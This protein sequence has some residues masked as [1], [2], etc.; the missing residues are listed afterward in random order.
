[1]KRDQ[2]SIENLVVVDRYPSREDLYAY[3]FVHARVKS[4]IRE[5]L[6]TAVFVLN[7]RVPKEYTFEGVKVKQGNS[8]ALKD[9]IEIC[10]T[11]AIST[12]FL[13]KEIW[14]VIEP[15]SKN[16]STYIWLHGSEIQ[17]WSRRYFAFETKRQKLH[18]IRK[19][20]EYYDFWRELFYDDAHVLH[21]IFVSQYFANEVMDD[22]ELKL[23]S[24]K[25][26]VIH[27]FIDTNLFKYVKK[28]PE[29]R[30]RIL[31]IRPFASKKYANDLTVSAILDL[32]DEPFFKELSFTIVGDGDLF[33]ATVAPLREF[34]NVSL[35]KIFLTQSDIANMYKN[36]GVFINPTRWDSHGVSRDEAMSSGLVPITSDNSAIPEFVSN[37][38]GFLVETEDHQALARAIKTLYR[39]PELF[40]SKS[41]ASADRVRSQSD[42]T[43]TI[44]A[45]ISLIKGSIKRYGI[46]GQGVFKDQTTLR[47]KI[48]RDALFDLVD[49]QRG[50]SKWHWQHHAILEKELAKLKSSES[51]RL[52]LMITFPLRKLYHNRILGLPL[53]AIMRMKTANA[54]PIVASTDVVFGSMF[55][56]PKNR[57]FD[58]KEIKSVR[59]ITIAAI[60]DEFTHNSFHYECNLVQ[61]TPDGWFEEIEQAQPDLLFIESAWRGKD[62][63]WKDKINRTPKELQ[64]IIDYCKSRDIPTVFWNKEDPAHTITFMRTAS[65]FDYVFTTDASC[66]P[67]YREVLGHNRIY[68]LPF[69]AQP[70]IHNPIEEY[71]RKDKFNFAGSYYARFK[72]RCRDFDTVM[73]AVLSL[74]EVD[75][76][77]RYYN[78]VRTHAWYQFPDRYKE[79]IVG[80]LP[81][82]DINKAYKGYR[83]AITMNTVKYS[84]TMF[85]RRAFELL[86]SNTIT[87]GN[88]SEGVEAALGDMVISGK[89]SAEIKEQFNKLI[90]SNESEHR[91]RLLGL[92]SI[93]S[94]HTYEQ[95]LHRVLGKVF[96]NFELQQNEPFAVIIS[97]VK[98][99][100]EAKR[101]TNFFKQ[102]THN[103]RKLYLLPEGNVSLRELGDDEVKIL[104]NK[105]PSQ[106]AKELNNSFFGIFD[107]TAYYGPH[108][109]SD[110]LLSIQYIDADV[111]GKAAY[112]EVSAPDLFVRNEGQQYKKDVNIS[113]DRGLIKG[114]KLKINSLSDIKK[115]IKSN[116]V[117]KKNTFGID[118]FSYVSVSE[119]TSQQK[120]VVDGVMN[121]DTGKSIDDIYKDA[122][123][124][125]EDRRGLMKVRIQKTLRLRRTWPAQ[126]EL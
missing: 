72:D 25:Y 126:R 124:I 94:Q 8:E 107:P 96:S 2:S 52:G 88:Y 106:F 116:R 27:N 120:E 114:Q 62:E 19:Y 82:K 30:K 71:D 6:K 41:Q 43:R 70:R 110:I 75:I 74:K 55:K 81:Y 101:V 38:E 11:K 115:L 45:E 108:Y 5:G 15:F 90:T 63:L 76:Y 49:D 1:M 93:L 77:D 84:P 51:Y 79:Y 122:D 121:I 118:E 14:A 4:Y 86:A 117:Y 7:D 85:A 83:Y 35:K 26:S 80:N 40:L 44:Q 66:I 61:L 39:D 97:Q 125:S 37:K 18:N 95:R 21:F 69:A 109:V 17:D 46:K 53:R 22:L 67:F 59:E 28:T 24:K 33:D 13:T 10:G 105:L 98:S 12:H 64:D 111:I 58:L 103:N 112:Y 3:A 123:A 42:F 104:D 99:I 68:L 47:E 56:P 54:R 34:S 87:V 20:R 119:L 23:D 73:N 92:R 78:P 100:D 50:L 36:H 29:Q 57:H 32:K 65:L 31:S 102:Q 113:L 60:T 16:I 48:L 9:Y 89:N 91:L